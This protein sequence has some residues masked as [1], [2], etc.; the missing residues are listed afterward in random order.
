MYLDAVNFKTESETEATAVTARSRRRARI[1]GEFAI[2]A[3]AVEREPF[4]PWRDWQVSTIS[5][6]GAE[7]CEIARHWLVATDHSSLCGAAPTTGPRWLRTRW[8][9]GASKFPIYW[10][11]AIERDTLDCGALAAFSYEVFSGRGVEAFRVQMVQRYSKDSARQWNER[12]NECGEPL[13]WIDGDLIY[14]EGIAI[15]APHSSKSDSHSHGTVAQMPAP[16]GHAHSNGR[17]HLAAVA[18][19]GAEGKVMSFQPHRAQ[20]GDHSH[21]GHSNIGNST[22]VHSS[23]SCPLLESAHDATEIAV[24]DSSA[25]WWSD[26]NVTEGYGATVAIKLSAGSGTDAHRLFRWGRHAIKAGEWTRL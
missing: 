13:R 6:H 16:N 10:C 9:W 19:R 1:T 18:D 21:N 5:H 17:S 26:P 3:P 15:A 22:H 23:T 11:D 14:H 12:W 24:W 2:A 25:G 7:C 4:E 20:A 8:R